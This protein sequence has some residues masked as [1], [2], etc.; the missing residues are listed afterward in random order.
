MADTVNCRKIC[1][2]K[3]SAAVG[4]VGTI[5]FLILG[6]LQGL[7]AGF[8]V[9]TAQRFGAGDMKVCNRRNSGCAF[10][11]GIVVITAGSMLLMKPLLIFMHT[12][13]DIILRTRI[14]TL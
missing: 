1:R 6:F 5:M 4:S 9:L 10:R 14:L 12:P 7:T 3:S 11:S 2:N 8:S 13:D